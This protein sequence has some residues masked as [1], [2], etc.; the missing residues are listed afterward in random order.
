MSAMI[1]DLM[2]F[3]IGRDFFSASEL[4]TLQNAINNAIKPDGVLFD[5]N[6]PPNKKMKL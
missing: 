3:L 2:S 4:H 1:V 5:A 6:D